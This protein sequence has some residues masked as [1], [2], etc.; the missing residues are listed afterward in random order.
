MSITNQIYSAH[1]L[2]G[3]NTRTTGPIDQNALKNTYNSINTNISNTN[4]DFVIQSSA[5]NPIG[6][7]DGS[8]PVEGTNIGII[9]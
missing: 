9:L 2:M 1:F 3:K 8:S 4:N 7:E 6:K 5:Q